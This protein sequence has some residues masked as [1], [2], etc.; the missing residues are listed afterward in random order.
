M[1]PLFH[2]DEIEMMG[3]LVIGGIVTIDPHFS[4]MIGMIDRPSHLG[5]TKKTILSGLS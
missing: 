5:V 4:E 3:T 1:S 2:L